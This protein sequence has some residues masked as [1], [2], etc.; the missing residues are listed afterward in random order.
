MTV[1]KLY[2]DQ[3]PKWLYIFRSAALWERY[4][5]VIVTRE[6]LIDAL[7]K[8]SDSDKFLAD[9]QEKKLAKKI[10]QY[11]KLKPI[12]F[13]YA[14]TSA[15]EKWEEYKNND[16]VEMLQWIYDNISYNSDHTMNIIALKKIF[17]EDISWNKQTMNFNDAKKLAT[18]KWYKLMTDYNDT[19]AEEIKKQNDWYKVINLFSWSKW[20]TREWMKL[21]RDMTW[22]NHWY[23]ADAPYKDWKWR[24]IWGFARHRGLCKNKDY[25][26]DRSWKNT[27]S[28]DC[29]CGFKDME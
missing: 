22:C 17:C 19:D 18:S 24:L 12:W 2:I 13:D 8:M 16:N 10:D 25:Y 14:P 21:F 9:V 11:N 23:W 3:D 28:H 5:D 27:E 1:S 6:E 7:L 20:D 29:V 15:K 4:Q 26:C